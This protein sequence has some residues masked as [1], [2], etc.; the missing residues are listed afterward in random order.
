MARG[1]FFVYWGENFC[2]CD[3]VVSPEVLT[4]SMRNMFSAQFRVVTESEAILRYKWKRDTKQQYARL[5]TSLRTSGDWIETHCVLAKDQTRVM[6]FARDIMDD[7]DD[8]QADRRPIR[9]KLPGRVIP[10]ILTQSGKV[11]IVY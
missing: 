1:G 8:D 9:E 4:M 5:A 7:D 6:R 10:G 11:H 2:A 3:F